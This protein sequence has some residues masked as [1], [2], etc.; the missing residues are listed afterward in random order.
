MRR[1]GEK[2]RRL[3]KGIAKQASC[4]TPNWAYAEILHYI[5]LAGILYFYALEQLQGFHCYDCRIPYSW[6]SAR[7]LLQHLW[8]SRAKAAPDGYRP[9]HDVRP[10]YW[11]L[12][13]DTAN[14]VWDTWVTGEKYIAKPGTANGA[15]GS[16]YI[17]GNYR[18]TNWMQQWWHYVVVRSGRTVTV[19][20]NGETTQSINSD[21]GDSSYDNLSAF[22]IGG[23]ISRNWV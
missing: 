6:H 16:S 20:C 14:P 3:K 10:V 17:H 7:I 21:V 19:Y 18:T 8:N 4:R 13:K 15:D 9:L 12:H 11:R 22:E 2:R 5:F 23:C 1:S